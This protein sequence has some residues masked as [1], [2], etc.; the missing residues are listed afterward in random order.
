MFYFLFVATNKTHLT[1][2]LDVCVCKG[3]MDFAICAICTLLLCKQCCLNPRIEFEFKI[4]NTLAPHFQK[5]AK[6][7]NWN[8]L[9]T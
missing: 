9:Y 8:F 3:S 1:F 5:V 7:K 2:S 4:H 6:I